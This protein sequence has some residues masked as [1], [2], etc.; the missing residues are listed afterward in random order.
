M[1]GLNKDKWKSVP[2]TKKMVTEGYL[3]V[4]ANAGG[5]GVDKMTIED[6]EGDLSN[7]LYKLPRNA[8]RV[9]E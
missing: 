7:Q 6:L 1:E 2:I 9:M 8:A 3:R 5:A 4:K